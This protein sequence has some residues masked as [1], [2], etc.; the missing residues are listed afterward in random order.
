MD[1]FIE[2]ALSNAAISLALAFVA[3]AVGVTLKRPGLTHLLWLIVLVKLVTPSVMTVPVATFPQQPDHIAVS[4]AGNSQPLSNISGSDEEA[5]QSAESRFTMLA[6]KTSWLIILWLSGSAVILA[7][8][9][10][11]VYR[12]NSLLSKE[13]GV[14]PPELQ[15]AAVRIANRLNL[16]KVPIIYTTS[17]NLSPM[18]WWIGGKVRV[19]IPMTL[20]EKMDTSQFHLILAHELAHVRRRDYLVRLIEWLACICF[21]WNPV[22]YWARSN[23]R[24]NEELCCDA[25]VISRLKPKSYTYANSLL[26]A[27][28]N[29]ASTVIRSP[30]IAS[31]INSGGLLERRFDMILSGTLKRKISHW[32]LASVVMCAL[33]VLSV[34]IGCNKY[35]AGTNSLP[36]V[37]ASDPG[38]SV[39]ECDNKEVIKEG[40]DTVYPVNYIMPD[41]STFTIENKDNYRDLQVFHQTLQARVEKRERNSENTTSYIEMIYPVTYIMP[42]GSTLIVENNEGYYYLQLWYEENPDS[43]EHP[44]MQYPVQ[45]SIKGDRVITINSDNEME[46]AKQ[47]YSSY[48]DLN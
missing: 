48:G 47:A 45:L 2:L 31:E 18:V 7:F 38:Q 25:L 14:A 13:S 27:F 10:T 11:R 37:T 42:D 1:V 33:V 9:L 26:K 29:L 34:G 43:K 35:D 3:F 17:T 21:W 40:F 6:G 28:E 4:I 23:L 32:M 19:I 41:G 22:V 16:K 20:I 24:N 46:K 39:S 15:T 5:N 30:A 8:S 12:F 44:S 36:P